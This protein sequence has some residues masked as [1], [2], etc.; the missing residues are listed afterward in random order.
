MS[1]RK[2]PEHIRRQFYDVQNRR[3]P[4]CDIEV[5]YG[6]A[7]YE[8]KPSGLILDQGCWILVHHMR[9]KRGLVLD[10]AVKLVCNGCIDG[11][12]CND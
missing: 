1:K 9:K 2:R 3:C 8:D 7:L 5:E 4:V 11:M 6:K 10:N 12:L